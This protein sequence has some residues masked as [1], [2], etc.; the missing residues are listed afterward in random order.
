MVITIV[1]FFKFL[2]GEVG[3][4]S[5]MRKVVI[6]D[7]SLKMATN[8]NRPHQVMCIYVI[9]VT[10]MMTTIIRGGRDGVREL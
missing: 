6:N 10:K 8:Q 7:I 5:F 3:K 4:V 1:T 9:A 2:Q